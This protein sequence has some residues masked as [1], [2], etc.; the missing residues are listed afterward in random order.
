MKQK[1]AE[2][3]REL[4]M[5]IPFMATGRFGKIGEAVLC[6]RKEDREALSQLKSSD[7]EHERK[8]YT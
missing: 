5:N 1:P 6:A 3:L 4:V 2:V 7:I 8:P